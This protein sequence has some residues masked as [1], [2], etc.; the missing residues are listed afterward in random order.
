MSIISSFSLRRAPKSGKDATTLYIR[1]TGYDRMA[2]S[3][4][5]RLTEVDL[6]SNQSSRGLHVVTINRDTLTKVD[7]RNFDTYGNKYEQ[8]KTDYASQFLTSSVISAH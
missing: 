7:E 4:C 6:L 1:G 2:P 5:S 3:F 8:L